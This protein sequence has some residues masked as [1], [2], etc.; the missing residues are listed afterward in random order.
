M[1]AIEVHGLTKRFGDFT[2]LDEIDLAVERGIIF[3]FLGPNGAGKTT[4][5]RLMTGLAR[6]T[7]GRVVIEGVEVGTN[8][9]PPIGYLP[10]APTFYHWMNAREFLRYIAGLHGLENPPIDAVLERVGLHDAANSIATIVSTRVLRPQYAVM[11]A[12]FF[13]FI[14]FLFFG[15][16]VAETLGK[17]IINA[18]TVTPAVVFA[19][20]TGAISWNIIT[21]MGGIPSSSS[22]A[23][24]GGLVQIPGVTE[25]VTNFLEPTFE[26]SIFAQLGQD[27]GYKQPVVADGRGETRF[28]AAGL[29]QRF[30]E[31]GLVERIRAS[32]HSTYPPVWSR[33]NVLSGPSLRQPGRIGKAGR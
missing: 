30:F 1:P 31:L 17:G 29:Q 25:V 24:I 16:H 14:A 32:G 5:L 2:A 23:L 6:P 26:H 9:R 21:W 10:D 12:A 28:R 18:D 22:H 8:R 15:L 4:T 13:N 11:W 19:A 33:A 27:E 7:A 20:L 3:G